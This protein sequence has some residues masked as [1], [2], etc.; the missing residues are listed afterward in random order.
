VNE[1]LVASSNPDIDAPRN[2]DVEAIRAELL[3]NNAELQRRIWLRDP[4]AWVRECAK[5]ELWSA[6]AKIMEAV[7]DY[8]HVA[9]RSSFDTGKSAV[10][11]R[12]ACWWIATH[13]LGEAFVVTTATTEAQVKAI[14]WHEIGEVHAAA[15]LVGR[16]NQTEWWAN[17]GGREQMI[18]FGRK[19]S[20]TNPTAL[21]GLHRRYVLVVLDEA[22]HDNQTDVMTARGWVRFSDVTLSDR[23]LTMD[24]STGESSYRKPTK[25][26]AKRY[27]GK[28]LR[29]QPR[30]GADFCVTPDHNMWAQYV[31]ERKGGPWQRV[32]AGDLAT[33][34]GW[35]ML[36][37]I[38]WLAPDIE[39]HDIPEFQSDRKFFPR[40]RFKMDLWLKFLA[41]YCSEGHLADGKKNGKYHSTGITQK[42][43]EVLTEIETLCANLGYNVRRYNLS[44]QVMI[45]NRQLAQHLS[46]LGVGCRNKRLPRY[47]SEC[48]VRQI[49]IFLD[50]YVR[51][52]GY[53]RKK[54]EVIYT[55]SKFMADDLQELILKTGKPSVIRTRDLPPSDFGDHIAYPKGIGYT[56]SRPDKLTK[57]AVQ[58]KHFEQ[59]KYD[60]MVYCA[61]VPPHHL[62]LTRRNGYSLWSGN[63]G[64]P[65]VLWDAADSLASNEDSRILAIGNPTDP[66]SE[67]A[68][69]SKPGSGWK[70][71]RISAFDTPAFTGEPVSEALKA[72]LVSRVWVDERRRK[73]GEAS[74][75]YIS[76]VLGEFP[77]T[78]TD[79]L[80]PI[81]W[82]SKAQEAVL[83]L[84]APVVGGVDVGAGGDRTVIAVRHGS[85]VRIV[86]RSQKRNTMEACG[87]VVN[88]IKRYR[89]STIHIDEIGIG[90]GL[91][92]RLRE[93]SSLGELPG[94][95]VVGVNVGKPAWEDEASYIN[96]RAWGYAKLAEM[97]QLERIDIDPNDEDLAA[98]LAD[99]K[100]RRLSQGGKLQI[101][102]KHEMRQRGR[103]SP[104]EAD[105]VMLA[106]L[107]ATG[108]PPKKTKAVWGTGRLAGRR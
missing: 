73:W 104:D 41:W 65:A 83:P 44:G 24:P 63:S 38:Q 25:L 5:G 88:A 103:M 8:R 70:T 32:R 82:I 15:G 87:D 101:E 60:G 31:N 11:G 29:Y 108:P 52:D 18:G 61:T 85:H 53:R 91:V 96:L 34:N 79:S 62:L 47:V 4:A 75:R 81:A 94:V 98:Q 46:E 78:S 71:I 50:T 59:I 43:P 33:K 45:H 74:S 92:D 1:P 67:F 80:I 7:R 28:M 9:V 37:H 16:L 66:Q 57:I 22:C 42:T 48:S 64:I 84:E 13:P 10:A 86:Y 102:G 40:L 76:M 21:Q 6:Q 106:C 72:R 58:P 51:G 107:P 12:I 93:M 2:A 99:L 19:P 49:N 90:R 56:V 77:E 27:R 26:I 20:D 14:L 55:S 39:Y 36:K 17:I 30:S 35:T 100:F 95:D 54:G 23:L 69:V 3:R 97:F 89:L 68:A 105:A